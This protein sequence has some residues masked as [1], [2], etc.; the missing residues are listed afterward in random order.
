MAKF[1]FRKSFFS[2]NKRTY[3]LGLLFCL[4]AFIA[5]S[6]TQLR[7]QSVNSPLESK[8]SSVAVAA[9]PIQPIPLKL[10]LDQRKVELGNKLFNDPKLSSDNSISCATCH[11][12]KQGGTERLATSKGMGDH[13][14]PLNSPTVFNSGFQWRQFWDGRAETLEEQINGPISSVGEMGGMS[15]WEVVKKLQQDPQYVASFK[16]IYA[17]GITENNIQNAIAT[18]E[19]SLYTPNSPFDK[20]L[21]GN[22]NAIT[23]QAKE[24]YSLFKSYGC[25]TCHQGM[26]V[27]GNMFQTFGV[28]GDY[29]ADRGNVL[30]ADL[31]RYNLTKDDL[32]R[33]V[34]KVPSLRNIALTAPYFHDGNAETL[35]EAIKIMGKYQ[36]GVK[37]PQKDVDLIMKFLRTL[38]GEY[39]G[40]KL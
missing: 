36:L 29:F 40:E 28:F 5:L 33:H 14:I 30:K 25:V 3:I 10:E 2:R 24:G 21:R 31:G 16:K 27:G 4:A 18:F 15:W 9:E 37:I 12:L 39:Q 7:E 23:E 26:L 34:F 38:T 19:R 17:N 22:E 8:I 20:Y 11:I 13:K 35:D 32:D 1:S 6:I